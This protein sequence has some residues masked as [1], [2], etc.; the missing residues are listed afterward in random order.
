MIDPFDCRE[1]AE[2][3]VVDKGIRFNLQYRVVEEPD[4]EPEL[5]ADPVNAPAHYTRL[6]PEP[7]DVVNDWAMNFNL[8]NVVKYC[9]RAGHKDG[10]DATTDLKKAEVYL[11]KEIQR[12]EK[13]RGVAD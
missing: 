9:A 7:I 10:Q 12:L 4:D 5:A 6:S 2:A 11:K 13:L 1:E 8:G 3:T